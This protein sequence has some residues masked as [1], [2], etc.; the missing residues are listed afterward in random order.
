M[1]PAKEGFAALPFFDEFDLSTVDILL[2]SQYVRTFLFPS[3][4]FF[5]QIQYSWN[6][7]LVHWRCGR[8]ARIRASPLEE[9]NT[10]PFIL[11]FMYIR[12]T[13]QYFQSDNIRYLSR[14]PCHQDVSYGCVILAASWFTHVSRPVLSSCRN[15]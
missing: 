11:D 13:I 4:L 9:D 1:H 15:S 6:I 5:A 14:T 10:A 8:E 3:S 12:E 2:I 7:C